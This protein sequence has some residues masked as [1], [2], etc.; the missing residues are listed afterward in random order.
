M[1]LDKTDSKKAVESMFEVGAHYGYNKSRRHPSTKP[2][3]F[4]TK[5]GVELIDLEKTAEL[6]DN[7]KKAVF[8][9]AKNGGQILF[10]GS[11]KE[12]ASLVKDSAL[13]VDQPYVSNRWIGGTITN[14]GEIQKRVRKLEDLETQ[15]EK[16]LLAKYTKK[17]RLLIDRELAK[18]N[19]RFGGIVIM[20][21]K[22]SALFIVDTKGEDAALKEAIAEGIPV[23][24]LAN[25]DCDISTIQYS[26][27]ANDSSIKSVRFFLDEIVESIREGQKE[28]K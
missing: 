9:V 20:K 5:D 22:P 18:L 21:G 23:I 8:E 7:A 2:F 28:K 25:S 15:K 10:V 16:G 14:F 6:L 11:K 1:N 19:E 27:V 17:E 24:G 4:G 13:K 3:I 12:V 26:I